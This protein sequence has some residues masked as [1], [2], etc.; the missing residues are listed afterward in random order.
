MYGNGTLIQW[1]SGWHEIEP[2][3]GLV[4]VRNDGEVWE[5]REGA[6]HVAKPIPGTGRAE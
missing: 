1:Q 4:I 5:Y 2:R 3:R 6:F